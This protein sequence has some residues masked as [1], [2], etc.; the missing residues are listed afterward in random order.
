MQTMTTLLFSVVFLCFLFD[1]HYITQAQ[2]LTHD[3]KC[4]KETLSK[5]IIIKNVLLGSVC[6]QY[7]FIG[8]C[9]NDNDCCQKE[10]YTQKPE[11]N[12]YTIICTDK[13]DA[14]NEFVVGMSGLTLITN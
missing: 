13:V 4:E 7:N 11:N 8:I 6:L 10:I 5:K 12:A 1:F 9:S 3:V 14:K 2:N